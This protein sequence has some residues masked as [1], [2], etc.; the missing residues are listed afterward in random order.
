M[1]KASYMQHWKPF[2]EQNF[3][4]YAI[5]INIILK[6]KIDLEGKF[7]VLRNRDEF[8]CNYNWISAFSRNE[9]RLSRISSSK[10]THPIS[11][12]IT[13]RLTTLQKTGN[14][15]GESPLNSFSF[16]LFLTWIKS[17]RRPIMLNIYAC[18]IKKSVTLAARNL[19]WYQ[20]MAWYCW[21]LIYVW[22]TIYLFTRKQLEAHVKSS[23]CRKKTRTNSPLQ[24]SNS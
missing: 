9:K 13:W 24:I 7:W 17:K 8:L 19:N 1:V 14:R 22:A 2:Q 5:S 4:L 3:L 15:V 18:Y 6:G 21:M 12:R 11:W 16:F 23:D 20:H 10:K